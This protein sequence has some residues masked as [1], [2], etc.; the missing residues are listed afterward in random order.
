MPRHQEGVPRTPALPPP[1]A[2]RRHL[3]VLFCDLVGSTELTGRLEPEDYREVVRA[4]HQILC[5]GG[6]PV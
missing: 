3:T 5:R 2:E 1:E 6:P 4:Y